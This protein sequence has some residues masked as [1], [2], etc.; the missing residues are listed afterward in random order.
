[1]KIPPKVGMALIVVFMVATV[2]ADSA[3]RLMSMLYDGLFVGLA[4]F[5]M[6]NMGSAEKKDKE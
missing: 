6:L 2:L 3:F 1:M 4:I 5:V